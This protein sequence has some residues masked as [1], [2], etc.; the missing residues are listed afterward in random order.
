MSL[1]WV[2]AAIAAGGLAVVGYGTWMRIQHP[3]EVLSEG[4]IEVADPGKTAARIRLRTRTV[5][6]GGVRMQEIELPN[7]TWID[8]SGDCAGAARKAGSDFWDERQK[9]SR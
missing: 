7:G 8:C 1:K 6:V 4:A 2:A 5:A 3:A 9:R